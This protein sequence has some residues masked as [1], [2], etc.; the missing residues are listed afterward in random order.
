M[1]ARRISSIVTDLRTAI[2]KADQTFD[3]AVIFTGPAY[4]F[5]ATNF[6]L[7]DAA[8]W[9]EIA[10]LKML[11]A[12]EALGLN[13]LREMVVADLKA[14]KQGPEG[15]IE[16]AMGP[17]EP[18]SRW[19]ARLRQYTAAIET[20]SEPQH[21]HLITKDLTD[22]LRATE[23][24]LVDPKLFGAPPKDEDDVHRRIEGVLRCVFPDLKHKPALTKPIKNFQPDT[25]LPSIRTLIEYKYLSRAESVGV[26]ADQLLADSHGYR[27]PEWNT[28]VYVIYE[29]KRFRPET[30]WNQF[31]ESCGVAS[32]TTVI[33]IS[34]E[35]APEE[36][37]PHTRRRASLSGKADIPLSQQPTPDP[38]I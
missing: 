28:F 3:H 31:L 29:T 30:E 14:A 21:T 20:L 22:I 36:Q 15:L 13:H 38:L 12:T 9:I 6:D 1:E 27:S 37:S 7:E 35:P 18:Y 33:V 23:Y 10:F 2:T 24:V 17:E 5:D 26:I 34:G 32:N 19:L 25:G 4:A 8:W 16:S 11:A